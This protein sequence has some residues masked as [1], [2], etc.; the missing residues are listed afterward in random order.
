MPLRSSQLRVNLKRLTIGMVHAALAPGLC[1]GEHSLPRSRTTAKCLRPRLPRY[2]P[3][4]VAG[5]S[6]VTTSHS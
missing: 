1:A 3:P 5:A 4:K 2:S 6:M